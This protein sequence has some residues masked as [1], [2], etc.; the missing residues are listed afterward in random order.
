MGISM[1]NC[2]IGFSCTGRKSATIHCEYTVLKED[3][4]KTITNV[5]I[6]DDEGKGDGED[7]VTPGMYRQKYRCSAI[8]T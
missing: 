4:G 2:D 1:G 7:P 3:R 8:S 6:A 5:A